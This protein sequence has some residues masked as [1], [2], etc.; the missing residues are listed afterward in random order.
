[1][2]SEFYNFNTDESALSFEF[3]SV[4]DKKQSIKL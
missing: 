3:Q 1:M 4:S 2:K